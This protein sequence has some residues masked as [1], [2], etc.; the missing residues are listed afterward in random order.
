V[1]GVL[2]AGATGVIATESDPE[3]RPH[4]TR[5]DDGSR[6]V[7]GYRFTSVTRLYTASHAT[8]STVPLPMS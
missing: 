6:R 5:G 2:H 4:F 7:D 8:L 1:T 3:D